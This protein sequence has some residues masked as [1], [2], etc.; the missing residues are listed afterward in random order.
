M[1]WSCWDVLILN[2]VC[3]F[4]G[5][6]WRIVLVEEGEGQSGECHQRAASTAS[7]ITDLKKR[8]GEGGSGFCTCMDSW[9]PLSMKPSVQPVITEMTDSVRSP[10]L[11]Q[12]CLTFLSRSV[13]NMSRKK[14]LTLS[15]IVL[16]ESPGVKELCSERTSSSLGNRSSSMPS[17]LSGSSQNNEKPA[18][19]AAEPTSSTVGLSGHW[20]EP[21]QPCRTTAGSRRT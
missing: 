18:R 9:D 15:T 7:E 17:K 4:W 20:S 1:P 12:N 3:D 10:F 14:D 5:G 13:L 6:M 21:R 11:L 8:R 2:L 16:P 19:P